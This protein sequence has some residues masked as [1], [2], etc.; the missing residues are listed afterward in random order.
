M[1]TEV[2]ELEQQVQSYVHKIE[3]VRIEKESQIIAL[4]S[5]L[6]DFESRV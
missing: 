6:V 5:E 3:E 2:T 1:N 4:K